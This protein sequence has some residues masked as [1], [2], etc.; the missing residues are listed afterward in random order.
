[1]RQFAAARRELAAA[2]PVAVLFDFGAV[3]WEARVFP[4]LPAAAL[5]RRRGVENYMFRA[6]RHCATIPLPP[7][8][9]AVLLPRG[10]PCP[11]AVAPRH[12]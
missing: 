7:R 5:V 1:P 11:A 3:P 2:P 10:T 4:G 8:R 6:Y 12:R 9:W